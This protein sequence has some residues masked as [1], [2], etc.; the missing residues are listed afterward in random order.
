MSTRARIGRPLT[1]ASPRVRLFASV[2][3]ETDAQIARW[4]TEAEAGAKAGQVIDRL[5]AHGLA[6]AWS[7]KLS[8][9]ATAKLIPGRDLGTCSARAEESAEE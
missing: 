4:R 1:G 9:G 3:S 5:V 7:P 2:A 6:S 8:L